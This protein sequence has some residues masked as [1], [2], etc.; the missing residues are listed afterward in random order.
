MLAPG[1]RCTLELF[2]EPRG[3]AFL[4]YVGTGHGDLC[5]AMKS[6][7]I[8]PADQLGDGSA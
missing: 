7:G 1:L 2:G 8:E 4:I 5:L 3:G 6:L